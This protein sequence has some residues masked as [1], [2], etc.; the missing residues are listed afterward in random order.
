MV[1]A[2]PFRLRRISSSGN[3]RIAFSFHPDTLA[4]TDGA[5]SVELEDGNACHVSIPHDAGHRIPH[6]QME[7][8]KTDREQKWSERCIYPK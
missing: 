5:E 7:M 1:L 2:H 4:L 6:V 8:P 3:G